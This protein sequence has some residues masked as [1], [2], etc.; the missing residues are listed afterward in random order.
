MNRDSLPIV[1]REP[2]MYRSFTDRLLGGVCGGIAQSLPFTNSWVI[3]ALFIVGTLLTW[4]AF[5]LGYLMLWMIVPQQSLIFPRRGGLGWGSVTVLILLAVLGLSVL[6]RYGLLQT[7]DQPNLYPL[8]LALLFGI[9][10]FMRQL[11]RSA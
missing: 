7:A 5:A 10:F 9:F 3:R 1:L 11:G 8:A 4:G 6:N 2:I